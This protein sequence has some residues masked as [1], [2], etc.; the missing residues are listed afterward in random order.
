MARRSLGVNIVASAAN[1]AAVVGASLLAVPLL[2]HRLGLAGYGVWTIAQTLVIY[3]T[4]AELGFGPALARF[5][6]VHRNDRVA[7]RQILVTALG[8]YLVVAVVLVAAFHLTAGPLVDVFDV[9]SRFRADAEVTV[10]LMGW[11][12]AIALVASAFGHVLSGMERFT[13]FT[14]TNAAG[15]A[16]FLTTLAIGLHENA[17]LE[18]A[19]HAALW[20]WSTVAVL[21]LVALAE[22]A[23]GRGRWRPGR[24]LL[25]DLLSYS[26]RLQMA[27]FATLLN[28]QTDRVVVGIVAPASTLGQVSIATQA[29]EAG[30]FLAYAA[31]TPL[32]A[33]MAVR[34][35]DEGIEA[36]DAEL[37][38]TR[39]AWIVA[40]VGVVAVGVGTARPV[41]DAWVGGGH[42]QAAGYAALL[43]TAYG[44]GLLPSP[45]FAYLRAIGQPGLEGTFG[46]VTVGVNLVATVVLGILAGATGVVLATTAAYLLSTLWVTRRTRAAVPEMPRGDTTW[47][48]LTL[49]AAVLAGVTYLVGEALS[50]SLPGALALLALTPVVAV[51]LVAY[52][53]AVYARSPMAVLREVRAR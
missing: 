48:R 1:V 12:S 38:R 18:D 31:F 17:Q 16:V 20:Q 34:Y 43:L 32:A 7:R 15:S 45:A 27:T 35:G 30:R 6:S 39:H 22:L 2:V 42:D 3:V 28:T 49:S 9:P 33:R 53:C 23:R 46:L 47:M 13:A 41:M 11:V 19:A 8:A 36:L 14:I 50:S 52:G 10:R 4:S 29:A 25:R 40:V 26:A 21:R 37:Q 24:A 5:T 44:V 51:G